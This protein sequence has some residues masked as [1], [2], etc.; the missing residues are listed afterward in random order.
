M[1][2]L[3]TIKPNKGATKKRKRV[4]RGNA[5]GHGT[6]SGRGQKG[7]KSRTGG[8]SGLKRK[9]MKQILLQTPKLR[10]FKSDKPKNQVVNLSVLNNNFKDRDKINP[11]SLLKAGLIDTMELP[12]KILGKGELQ[13]KNLEF[14]DVKIS[15]SAAEQIKKTGGKLKAEDKK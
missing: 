9:G 2:L 1:L 10:G 11:G 5:S 14:S 13:L 7:Q 3:H 4:G 15:Q 6:Y 8:K 12:V